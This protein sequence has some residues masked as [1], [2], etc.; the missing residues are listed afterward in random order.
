MTFHLMCVDI[1]LSSIW[2]AEWSPFGKSCSLDWPY[3]LFVFYFFVI[4]VISNFVLRAGFGFLLLQFLVIAYVLP[5]TDQQP[6][7][8]KSAL[9]EF[10][11]KTPYTCIK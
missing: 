8:P 2:V 6:F 1:I 4:L 7:L 5:L 10:M 3:V 11:V 9:F